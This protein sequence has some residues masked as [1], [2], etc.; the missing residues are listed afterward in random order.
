[1]TTRIVLPGVP[2]AQCRPR[3]GK[4]GCY[5]PNAD[6]KRSTKIA[7]Y[8]QMIGDPIKYQYPAISMTFFMPIPSSLSKKTKAAYEIEW[9]R[10]IKK[11]DVDNLVKFY[12][13]CLVGI[14]FDD[15]ACVSLERCQKVYYGHPATIIEIRDGTPLSNDLPADPRDAID[16][17][18]LKR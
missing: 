5:N 1:M 2:V 6:E 3:L 10:H 18:S 14:F 8:A 9:H 11:P 16:Q 17:F 7:I 15:D 12:M 4:W 13:D